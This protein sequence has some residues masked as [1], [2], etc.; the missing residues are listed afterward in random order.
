M[1]VFKTIGLFFILGFMS[2]FGSDLEEKRFNIETGVIHYNILGGGQFTK[3]VNLTIKG[4]SKFQFK[5]WGEFIIVEENF[6]ETVTGAVNNTNKILKSSK[7]E[8]RQM[9]DVDFKNSKTLKITI[10]NGNFKS[11]FTK[12]LEQKGQEEIAGYT[13]D[14]WEGYGVKKCMYKGIPLLIENYL[15]GVYY[16]K[17]AT[18]INF[19]VE[20][21]ATD[22]DIPKYPIEN[23]ALL[24]VKSKKLPNELS[25]ILKIVSMEISK[26]LKNKNISEDSLTEKQKRVYLNKIGQSIFTKQKEL[27]PKVLF[28]MKKARVCLHG[29]DK[30][31]DADLCIKDIVGLNKE[32]NNKQK[33]NIMQW[34]DEEKTKIVDQFDQDIF[35]LES[36]MKCIRGSKNL[37]DLSNCMK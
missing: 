2:L 23:F 10:P 30:L 28:S 22:N 5:D 3:D 13:C 21:N 4:D 34:S 31:T 12:G 25:K 36:N 9:L 18:Q 29:V 20:I 14:I 33:Y 19:N 15:L 24:K 17:K 11:D 7:L 6:E 8:N 27:L 37:T 26:E 16:Q 32:L 1:H 35:L